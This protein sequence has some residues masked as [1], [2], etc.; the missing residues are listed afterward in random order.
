MQYHTQHKYAMLLVMTSRGTRIVMTSHDACAL[1]P[2]AS[3]GMQILFME[4]LGGIFKVNQQNWKEWLAAA[5]IGFGS[6]I[7]AAL[8]KAV[9]RCAYADTFAPGYAELTLRAVL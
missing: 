8:T 2:Y 7:V 6:M 1:Q 4:A 9:T 3:A 5:A